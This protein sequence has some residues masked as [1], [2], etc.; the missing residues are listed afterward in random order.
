MLT[1]KKITLTS[2]P[3]NNHTDAMKGEQMDCK[4]TEMDTAGQE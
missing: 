3:D 2:F 4:D 1:K